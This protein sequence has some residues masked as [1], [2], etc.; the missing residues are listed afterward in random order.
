MTITLQAL[1]LVIDVI[2]DALE[3][4]PDDLVLTDVVVTVH[5][6]MLASDEIIVQAIVSEAGAFAG[7]SLRPWLI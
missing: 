7:S 2:T 6:E 5:W 3:E 4:S 1:Q